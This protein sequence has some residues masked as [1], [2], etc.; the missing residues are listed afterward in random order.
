MSIEAQITQIITEGVEK[1]G[2]PDLF[3]APLVAFSDAHDERYESLKEVIGDWVR[4]PVE[5]LPS[6]KSVVSYFVPYTREIARTPNQDS[7]V[8]ALWGE[9]YVVINDHF[10]VI[11]GELSS[12]LKEQGFDAE[13]VPATHTYNP[14]DMHSAWSHRSAAAIAGLGYFAANRLVV[15][16]KGSAGRYCTLF[17]SAELAER[18]DPP[19]NRCPYL[20][21][22]SCGK[23]FD[24]CPVGALRPDGMDKFSCQDRLFEN[25]ALLAQD[26]QIEGADVCGKCLAACP[27]AYFE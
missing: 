16:E 13:A 27:L 11:N 26:A 19:L 9:A 6:A 22:G 12:F 17:T 23:C 3:R 25:E 15:T 2:R 4:T 18:R 24:A 20:K 5:F 8:S 21:D 7:Q 1:L 10:N 14:S